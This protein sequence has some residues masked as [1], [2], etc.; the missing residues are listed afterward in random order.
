MQ[1]ATVVRMNLNVTRSVLELLRSP[2][3][4]KPFSL[5]TIDTARARLGH[6]FCPVAREGFSA[7]CVGVTPTL[8][9]TPDGLEAYAV[10]DGYPV[11]MAPD[12]LVPDNFQ[13][14]TPVN[15]L[16]PRY[17]EA[18]EEMGHYNPFAERYL[19]RFDDTEIRALFGRHIFDAGGYEHFPEPKNKWIDARHDA[20]SQLD[21]YAYLSPMAKETFLQIG[22]SGSHAVKALLAGATEA[23]LLTPMIGEAKIARAMASRFGVQQ[24]LSCI[25][26]VGEELPF[27]DAS[28]SR[29]YSGGCIHHMQT[30]DAFRE[31]HRVLKPGGR[32]SA[33]DP[34][35]AP[36]HTIGTRIFGKREASVFCRPIDAARLAPLERYFPVN[37]IN[38]HGPFL[39]YPL[40]V[41]EK[42]GLS[43]EPVTM[44]RI[45]RMDDLL[46]RISGLGKSWSSSLMIGGT[47]SLDA[48]T[49]PGRH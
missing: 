32:F 36:L 6:S 24:R 25:I 17:R 37:L 2:G 7:P 3:S 34:W 18:Y 22:G 10:K 13:H 29:M 12:R 16:D 38:R 39:R 5:E 26:A 48:Q 30:A 49:S 31:I 1:L 15:L 42:M 8:L 20:Q 46:G 23:V 28:F 35:K 9:V 19:E 11:V 45:G 43:F 33:V 4:L 41:L 14:S 44:L 21:A 27:A 47:K 40:I